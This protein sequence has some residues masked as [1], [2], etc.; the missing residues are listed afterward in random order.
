MTSV[1]RQ[2]GWT[3]MLKKHTKINWIIEIKCELFARSLCSMV[4]Y[5]KHIMLSTKCWNTRQ[6][7]SL[8]YWHVQHNCSTDCCKLVCC[9]SYCSLVIFRLFS[10]TLC[11]RLYESVYAWYDGLL[12][13]LND[14]CCK[15][16][17]RHDR[18]FKLLDCQKSI[19]VMM[20]LTSP[21]HLLSAMLLFDR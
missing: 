13:S 17:L 10:L 4:V 1:T 9:R 15:T 2:E 12:S 20:M 7:Y 16:D 5:V 6:T 8:L 19:C 3:F 11:V 14:K 21:Q 18:W